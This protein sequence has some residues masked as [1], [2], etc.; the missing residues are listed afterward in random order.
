MNYVL[1]PSRYS[2]AFVFGPLVE[3]DCEEF[4]NDWNSHH[5]RADKHAGG[6]SGRPDD[7][8]DAPEM[9]GTHNSYRLYRV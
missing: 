3:R 1:H 8:F 4:L 5:I 6:P 9:F 7:L 2:L